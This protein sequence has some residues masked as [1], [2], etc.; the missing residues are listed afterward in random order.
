MVNEYA[1]DKLPGRTISLLD[2]LKTYSPL[3]MDIR[4]E[5]AYAVAV[6]FFSMLETNIQDEEEFRRIMHAWFKAV[7]DKDF[8]KFQ[9]AMRRYQ[10][11]VNNT[12]NS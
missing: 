1:R 3:R 4:A 7:R 10:R 2:E 11:D 5:N 8:K 6:K 9:R 12:D